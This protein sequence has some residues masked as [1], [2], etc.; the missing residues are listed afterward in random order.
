M[1]EYRHKYKRSVCIYVKVQ[2]QPMF[3][4]SH[5]YKHD[6]SLHID[7]STKKTQCLPIDSGISRFRVYI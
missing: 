3:M 7:F 6:Q 1:F 5:K 4:Y 2:T